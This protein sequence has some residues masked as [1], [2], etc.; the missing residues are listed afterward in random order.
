MKTQLIGLVVSLLATSSTLSA[1][2]GW[3]VDPVLG[4][5]LNGGLSQGDAFQTLTHALTQADAGDN[6]FCVPGTYSTGSGETFPIGLK[7]GVLI[8]GLGG[9][10]VF[11]GNGAGLLFNLAGNVTAETAMSGIGFTD[12]STLFSVQSGRSVDG[13]VLQNCSFS[14]SLVGFSAVLSTSAVG[15]SFDLIG[16]DFAAGAGTR[17]IS[18]LVSDGA[19]DDGSLTSNQILGDY[20][21]GIVLQAEGDGLITNGFVVQRNRLAGCSVGI[22]AH[23]A[24]SGGNLLNVA[25]VGAALQANLIDGTG[26]AS[27][28]G[29]AL[30][31]ELGVLSEGALVS[32]P[33]GFCVIVDYDVAVMSSTVNDTN[34]LADVTSDFYGN[35]LAGTET[36]VQIEAAQPNPLNR[37]SDPNFGGHPDGGISGYNTFDAF[38]LDFDLTTAQSTDQYA[39]FCWFD[40]A[41]VSQQG[42]LLTPQLL[43]DPLT[44][45]LSGSVTP[46]VAGEVVTL[47]ALAGS[48]FVDYALGGAI[49]QIAVELN[50]VAI[51]QADIE[52]A[53]P[54]TSMEITLPSIAGGLH[55]LEITN[56][57][58]QKG[59]FEFLVGAGSDDGESSGC[60]VATAAHGD[61]D[62]PEVLALRGL[63]D[64]YLATSAPG[65]SFIRW[66]YREG[67]AA[68]AWIAERP[69]ARAG[70]RVALQPAVVTSRALTQWNPGQR[71]AFAVLL[72]GASF[73]LLRRR[74]I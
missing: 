22:F 57:G 37:N 12:A 62:A 20:D 16:C 65:R 73:A 11:D 17:A 10:P 36:G 43:A 18:V 38:A 45:T 7:S 24:G 27:G 59:L 35:V 8:S 2:Q 49:G 30:M 9:I 3:F 61:Y 71:F 26:T 19:L 5:D 48:G 14:D 53:I 68:A 72:L 60:F 56:P 70:A 40:G 54:G 31:A 32:C 15:Q 23:A 4:D 41:P 52:A 29:L 46:N 33:V 34:N 64:E 1:Q 66:Y 6:I 51:P 25:T 13:L 39:A 28:V 50:G 44:A 55:E 58:G 63:R 42:T 74:S 69:W 47:T 67:P 21:E